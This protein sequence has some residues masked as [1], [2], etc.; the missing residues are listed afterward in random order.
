MPATETELVS[1]GPNKET[2][3]ITVLPGPPKASGSV[4]MKRTQ[5]LI[6]MPAPTAPV[7][8][9]NLAPK[10]ELPKVDAIS[11]PLCW[12]LLGT[13]AAILLIQIWNYLS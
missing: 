9:V 12:A 10:E 6:S 2:V 3:R 8:P 4:Q 7:T 13:S 5:P 11:M 1:P